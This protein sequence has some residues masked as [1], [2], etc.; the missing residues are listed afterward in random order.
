MKQIK[1]PKG[2][3]LIMKL[4]TNME[5]GKDVVFTPITSPIHKDLYLQEMVVKVQKDGIIKVPISNMNTKTRRT[6]PAA[7]QV[8]TVTELKDQ[9]TESGNYISGLSKA[10]IDSESKKRNSRTAKPKTRICKTNLRTK[11]IY[12]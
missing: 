4:K 11:E 10:I 7:V 1:V 6:A 2:E 3:T 12:I 8:G 9:T 5:Q